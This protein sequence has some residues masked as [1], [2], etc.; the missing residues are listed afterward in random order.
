M[1]TQTV[2]NRGEE[3]IENLRNAEAD[4]SSLCLA[5]SFEAD[6]FAFSMLSRMFVSEIDAEYLNE[7]VGMLYP[8]SSGND[9][10]DEGYRMLATYLSNVWEDSLTDL[11]VDYSR[12]FVGNGYDGHSAAYPFESVYVSEKRLLMQEARD[13]VLAI[14]RACGVKKLDKWKQA[15]DHVGV[16][17]EFATLLCRRTADYLRAGNE[18]AAMEQIKTL[19]NFLEDHL[20]PWVPM[21]AEDMRSFARTDFYQS[22]S[23]LV[24]GTLEDELLRMRSLLA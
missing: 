22:L 9:R 8:V 4:E 16:E 7:L 13:E 18:A 20:C 2:K 12:C 5:D 3:V 10:M 1:G 19:H 6:A 21:L 24:E 11:A 23:Y 15:E 14:Y 17:L